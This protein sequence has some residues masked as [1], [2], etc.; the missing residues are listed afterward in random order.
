MQ[1]CV[2]SAAPPSSWR[3]LRAYSPGLGFLSKSLSSR[4]QLRKHQDNTS[5]FHATPAPRASDAAKPHRRHFRSGMMYEFWDTHLTFEKSWLARL[6]YVHQILLKLALYP[7]ENSIP[8]GS[9]SC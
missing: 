9:A 2:F 7:V 5:R 3:K 6:N 1:N 4:G 8:G